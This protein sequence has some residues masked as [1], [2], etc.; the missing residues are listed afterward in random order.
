MRN[1]IVTFSLFLLTIIAM[2]ISVNYVN[3]T[4]LELEKSCNLIEEKINSENWDTAKNES[5]K[6]SDKWIKKYKKIA[7]F[8]D[9]T[10]ID[11]INSK[12]FEANEYIKNKD[13]EESIAS[14]KVIEYY[15]WHIRQL[16]Q[17][18]FSNIF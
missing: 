4:C 12:L 1:V 7:V 16:E 2:F 17:V 8:V 13:K 15:L 9:H 14:V 18:S 5:K 10:E 6:F 3:R 11:N